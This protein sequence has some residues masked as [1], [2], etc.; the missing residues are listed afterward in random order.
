[1]GGSGTYVETPQA[2]KP[3]VLTCEHVMCLQPQKHWPDGTPEPV[4]LSGQV[5]SDRHPKDA[6]ILRFYETDWLELANARAVPFDRFAA[7]HAPVADEVLFFYGVAGENTRSAYGYQR[8][9]TGY[10]TQEKRNTGDDEIFEMFWEP[11]HI[12]V[13]SQ[14]P[15]EVRADIKSDDPGG[16]SGSVVWNT[17]FVELGCDLSHW[18]P[19]DAVVTGLLRRWDPNSRTL[20]VWRAEHLTSWLPSA[21]RATAYRA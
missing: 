16:F 21:M 11:E 13:S 6:A 7:K 4:V 3:V 19:A 15:A 20:L 2:N 1:M 10:S 17:R 12:E 14:A 8:L 5:F 9:S 18:S